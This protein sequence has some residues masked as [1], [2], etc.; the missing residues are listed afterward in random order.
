MALTICTILGLESLLG[1]YKTIV[2]RDGIPR[3]LDFVGTLIACSVGLAIVGLTAWAFLS[4]L[5][6][7]RSRARRI[8]IGTAIASTVFLFC[9]LLDFSDWL[10]TVVASRSESVAAC[11]A[12]VLLQLLTTPPASKP[13][14]PSAR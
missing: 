8:A 1:I 12:L 6:S 4:E 5:I 10:R 2:F 11:L 3:I 13:T 14:P 9:N 7:A